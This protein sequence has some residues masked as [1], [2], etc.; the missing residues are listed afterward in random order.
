MNVEFRV[1]NVIDTTTVVKTEVE[2]EPMSATVPCV[3]VELTT[4]SSRHGSLTL[5]FVGGQVAAAREKFV[6][7]E[8]VTWQ[9]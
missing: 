6:K 2:G 5:R 7:G 8:T 4:E 3:E 1:Q 9:L